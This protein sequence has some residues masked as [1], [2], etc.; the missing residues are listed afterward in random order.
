MAEFVG[1][2]RQI[3]RAGGL[4]QEKRHF[5]RVFEAIAA[6]QAVHSKAVLPLDNIE[7]LFSAFQIA[8]VIQQMPGHR[9]EEIDAV[10]CLNTA[11]RL[12]NMKGGLHDGYPE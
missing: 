2:S 10:K 6:L 11:Q 7:A 9:R 3:L 1:R 12:A 5:E 4:G 8:S